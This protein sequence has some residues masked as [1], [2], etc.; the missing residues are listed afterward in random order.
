MTFKAFRITCDGPLGAISNKLRIGEEPYPM[1]NQPR[2]L[3][4]D[5]Q[6]GAACWGC[7]YELLYILRTGRLCRV[8]HGRKGL[9]GVGLMK[10]MVQG[11]D[12]SRT[13]LPATF[14]RGRKDCAKL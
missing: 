9:R 14:R 13:G 2:R 10:E 4:H 12:S 8:L 6:L 3:E 5:L 7:A 11:I 1:R